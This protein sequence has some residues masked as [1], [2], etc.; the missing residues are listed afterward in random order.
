MQMKD[1]YILGIH[2]FS[3]KSKRAMHNSGVTLLKNGELI[4]AADEERFTRKKNEGC[5]PIQSLNAMY[6]ETGVKPSQI[7]SIAMPDK[8]SLW[9][10][11]MI[12]KYAAQVYF[13]TGVFQNNYLLES[14]K[15]LSEIRRVLPTELSKAK[16]FYVEHHLAHAASVYYTCPWQKSTI[17]TIDG[18]GD[19][20]ISGL[21][22]VGNSGKIKVIDR[23]NGFYSPGLF[24]MIITEILGFVSG[25]HE[26]KVTGLAAYGKYN[27]KL[28]S[29][30]YDLIKYDRE[31]GD[32]FS[33]YVAYEINDY[34]S[35]KWVNGFNPEFGTN[36]FDEKIYEQQKP[37]QLITF[38][39]QLNG[40][41]KE[42]IA[43]AAQKRLEE[44]VTAHVNNT[45]KK[46]GIKNISLSGGVFA[47]VKLNQRIRELDCVDNV[48]IYPAMNDSG[49]SV[50]SA[51]FVH[52]N[53]FGKEFIYPTKTSML[54]GK[55]TVDFEI[56]TLLIEKNIMFRK[57][58][59][60]EME[61]AKAISNG[62]I[63]AH[64]YGKSEY[65]PRA[66]GNR[67]ILASPKDA[68]IN[69]ILNE[70]LKRTEFMPFAPVV[71]EEYASE[72][73]KDWTSHCLNSKFMT[74]CY[75]VTDKMK[76]LA[77]AVVH[78]DDTAR[79]QVVSSRENQRLHSILSH[80]F[81]ITGI[82][83]L[84]NTSFN[85]HEEP[86]VNSAEDAIKILETNAVD[87][88]TLNNFWIEL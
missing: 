8:N 83:V 24:Y 75:S 16:K 46:T 27:A 12:L 71:M 56:E 1:N 67:S 62:K 28:D 11:S 50:G 49:L 20:S 79:P 13:E 38:R 58:E 72:L 7:G 17:I 57:V 40:Y 14:F 39:N 19:F 85:L 76:C 64:F 43:F 34:I 33:K 52:H 78:I 36:S 59:N 73:F 45:V 25:R 81:K 55:S 65:G 23:L 21:T 31:K 9:Q 41:S 5:F 44:I 22:A 10:L 3:F 84:I 60:I 53:E 86:I 69:G 80:H 30:F 63:I 47:N 6:E 88:L 42:D 35:K 61:I 82:P 68:S 66:L 74:M 54:L 2:G 4:F 51:L 32:F 37:F 29:I 26:G 18:M 70:K 77:P 87:I 15:R 48:F